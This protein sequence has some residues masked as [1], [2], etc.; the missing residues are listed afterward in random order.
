MTAYRHILDETLKVYTD[1]ETDLET[2]IK[3]AHDPQW[4]QLLALSEST[5][6]DNMPGHLAAFQKYTKKHTST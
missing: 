1:I 3:L 4:S 6:L 5:P 2:I